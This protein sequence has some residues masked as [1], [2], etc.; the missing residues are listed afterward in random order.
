[1][2]ESSEKILLTCPIPLHTKVLYG[3]WFIVMLFLLR[4]SVWAVIVVCVI[5]LLY[6]D[7]HL[8]NIV[9]VEN[10]IIIY[11]IGRKRFIPWNAV[12]RMETI[13]GRAIIFTKGGM[14]FNVPR[15]IFTNGRYNYHE[16][17]KLIREQ[18]AV[19]YGS[20]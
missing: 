4:S 14:G 17:V 9:I 16:A 10:G 2:P 20:S 13:L 12:T 18:C 15:L 11:K 19:T 5:F 6:V 3:V 1:M 7:M 8:F